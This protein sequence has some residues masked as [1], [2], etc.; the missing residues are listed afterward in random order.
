MKK[1]FTVTAALALLCLCIVAQADVFNL[2][3]GFTN[4]ETVTVGDPYYRTNG[5]AF[6]NSQSAYGTFDQGGNVFEW[7]E[8]LEID[9]GAWRELRGGSFTQDVN[10]L[11]ASYANGAGQPASE[12]Y[13]LRVP[14][15]RNCS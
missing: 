12:Y 11:R 9:M 6:R 3:P 13:A 4:L 8:T 15:C 1:V 10:A 5:G 2:G 14:S 7:I